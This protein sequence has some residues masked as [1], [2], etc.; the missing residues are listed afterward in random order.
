LA[1]GIG[2]GSKVTAEELSTRDNGIGR[3]FNAHED[4]C[5]NCNHTGYR[6]RIGIYEVL[7]NSEAIQKEI[8]TNGTSEVIEAL[9]TKEGMVTM[10][11][12]GLVKALRGET[13]IS[14]VL[15]VTAQE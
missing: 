12:D 13:T 11:V 14:E 8:V 2:K 10:Q 9:A 15:R 1:D 7:S 5:E 3:L 4:G 6:G